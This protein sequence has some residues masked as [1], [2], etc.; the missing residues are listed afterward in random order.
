MQAVLRCALPPSISRAALSRGVQYG[1]A[2]VRHAVLCLL[3][4]MLTAL[5]SLVIAAAEA[6]A[7][8]PPSASPEL[9]SQWRQLSS[10]VQHAAR[11]ALPD[12]QPI[13]A[14]LAVASGTAKEQK[15]TSVSAKKEVA[16]VEEINLEQPNDENITAEHDV[17]EEMLEIEPIKGINTALFSATMH[18]LR[19]WRQYLPASFPE[20]N[21]DVEKLIPEDLSTLPPLHQLQYIFLLDAENTSPTR[22]RK[23]FETDLGRVTDMRQSGVAIGGGPAL[24]PMLRLLGTSEHAEGKQAA[25]DWVV[26][27]LTATGL[28]ES[29]I[30]ETFLWVDLISLN[31]GIEA[32]FLNDALG[33]VL[34]RPGEF[35]ALLGGAK[36]EVSLLLLCVLRQA[37]RVLGSEKKGLEEKTIIAQYVARVAVLVVMQQTG[38]QGVKGTAEVLLGVLR[39]EAVRSAEGAAAPMNKESGV[40]RKAQSAEENGEEIKNA[41]VHAMLQALGPAAQPLVVLTSWL[42]SISTGDAGNSQNEANGVE[43]PKKKKS[44]KDKLTMGADST[45]AGPKSAS[46]SVPWSLFPSIDAIE[47]N[48]SHNGNFIAALESVPL[49]LL[50]LAIARLSSDGFVL[51]T[52]SS[53]EGEI[54]KRL[55]SSPQRA[56]VV[57]RQALYLLPGATSSAEYSRALYALLRAAVSVA[58]KKASP[59]EY[60]RCLNLCCSSEN[61]LEAIQS[62]ISAKDKDIPALSST[63][64][65]TNLLKSLLSLELR[66]PVGGS[67]QPAVALILEKVSK[68]AKKGFKTPPSLTLSQLIPSSVA[69]A[70]GPQRELALAALGAVFDQLEEDNESVAQEWIAVAG[71]T[72][73]ALFNGKSDVESD[74]GAE[75]LKRGCNAVIRLLASQRTRSE[76]LIFIGSYLIFYASALFKFKY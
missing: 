17:D 20:S 60:V 49:Y 27:R 39:S 32:A 73:G 67:C 29:N 13:L 43:M 10:S 36:I 8:L 71:A 48:T 24:L 5:G 56:P 14:Q 26:G 74:N 50:P 23:H 16:T 44:K 59:Q 3:G 40:K 55:A 19:L 4:H 75:V 45:D 65:V 35:F 34:R 21:I 6:T 62:A 7:A 37:V 1:N 57:S 38:G 53:E 15:S 12:L 63:V 30:A 9:H 2:L 25:A 42:E 47:K 61:F 52:F 22:S 76:S 51:S 46:S 66:N 18:V 11:A 54:T 64:E 72:L 69:A 70:Q 41:A 28:F 68:A 31:N 33:L 58:S